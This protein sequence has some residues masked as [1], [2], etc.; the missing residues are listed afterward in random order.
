MCIASTPFGPL[1]AEA[2]RTMAEIGPIWGRD[3]Q[4]HRNLVVDAYTP[5][6]RR[7]PRDGVATERDLAYGSHPRQRLD[8]FRRAGAKNAVVVV[9]VHGGAFVRGEKSVNGE[10]YDNVP[11]WF[12]RQGCLGI[13]ME[14]RLAPEAPFPAGAED[15]ALAVQWLRENAARY[16]GNPER[17]FLL[18]HSAGGAHVATYAFDPNVAVKPGPE[19]AG[20]VLISGRLRADVHAD[21]PNANGVRAYWGDDPARYDERSPVTW[22]E[23]CRLPVMIAIAEYENP[24][25]DVYGAELF[26]RVS[27]ARKRSPRFV[28]MTDHNHTSL[29]A[30]FNSGEETLGPEILEFMARGA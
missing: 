7:S 17:I 25:L 18:G 14:Y 11:L 9:F 3:I 13:N 24:Y 1:S 5:I 30:H 26:H 10:V 16:G 29:V 23:H 27:L 12:A 15:V 6:L 20:I 19:L 22:A 4:Q 28:R 8:V 21:N 2:R